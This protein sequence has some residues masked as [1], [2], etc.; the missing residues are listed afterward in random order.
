M[1]ASVVAGLKRIMALGRSSLPIPLIV[2]VAGG[3]VTTGGASRC[4]N[5]VRINAETLGIFP[6]PGDGSLG[7]FHAFHHLHA[8]PGLLDAVVGGDGD[9]AALG[10][11]PGL[12]L[13]LGG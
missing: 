4:G 7:V 11:M 9:H 2:P 3:E 10:E 12:I 5:L 13:E 1:E 6:D 8:M